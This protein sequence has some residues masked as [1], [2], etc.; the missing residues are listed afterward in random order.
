MLLLQEPQGTVVCSV[1]YA[2]FM[3]AIY[4]GWGSHWCCAAAALL[5]ALHLRQCQGVL[6]MAVSL[7][8]IV[9]TANVYLFY[10]DAM[11]MWI[12]ILLWGA[13]VQ[14]ECELAQTIL[15]RYQEGQGI[16]MY[17]AWITQ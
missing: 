17:A 16:T 7:A 4:L 3:T 8:S 2:S 5:A 15:Q 9:I 1:C 12:Q 6:Q 11:T 10:Q 14:F 13:V